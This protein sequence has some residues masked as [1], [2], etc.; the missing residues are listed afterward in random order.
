MTDVNKKEL[1]KKFPLVLRQKLE[2]GEI[3]FPSATL[4]TYERIKTYRAINRKRDDFSAVCLDDFK[5]YFDLG[6]KPKGHKHKGINENYDK[7]PRYYGVSS[8]LKREIVELAMKFPNPNKKM[9]VGY[10]HCDG[11]PE[12]TEDNHVCWWLFEGADV[13]GFSIL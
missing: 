9:A 3:E 1:Y 5:S 8:S 12:C 4:F 2:S 6:K 13:S 10:V 7:D 11:G